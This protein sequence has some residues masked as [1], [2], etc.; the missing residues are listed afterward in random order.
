MRVSSTRRRFMSACVRD[1]MSKKLPQHACDV[2]RCHMSSSRRA[3][4]SS[5]AL[6]CTIFALAAGEDV[7]MPSGVGCSQPAHASLREA[8]V[9]SHESRWRS[10]RPFLH[11]EL[12][13][14]NHRL[15]WSSMAGPARCV[16]RRQAM[17]RRKKPLWSLNHALAARTAAWPLHSTRACRKLEESIGHSTQTRQVLTREEQKMEVRAAIK[18]ARGETRREDRG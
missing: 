15:R 1:R 11:H 18:D 17:R 13:A 9:S 2:G 14:A 10:L 3:S 16:R 7:W 5:T 12:Q 8:Q 6:R 4:W